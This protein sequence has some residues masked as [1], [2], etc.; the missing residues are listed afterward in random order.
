MATT[1]PKK[2]LSAILAMA[3]AFGLSVVAEGVETAAQRDFFREA[4]C[5]QLQGYFIGRAV[6]AATFASEWLQYPAGEEGRSPPSWD[7]PRLARR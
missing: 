1:L 6:P 2:L 3:R 7:A 4:R 5:E